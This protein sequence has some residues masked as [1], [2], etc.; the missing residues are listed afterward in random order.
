MG[1]ALGSGR[2]VIMLL[3]KAQGDDLQGNLSKVLHLMKLSTYCFWKMWNQFGYRL[4]GSWYACGGNFRTKCCF[5]T[6]LILCRCFVLASICEVSSCTSVKWD[7]VYI[8]CNCNFEGSC[9]KGHHEMWI[10]C[11]IMKSMF[12]FLILHKSY[13]QLSFVH[14]K[15]EI[16]SEF[17]KVGFAVSDSPSWKRTI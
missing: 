3:Q 1:T 17:M 2:I 10:P 9:F 6:L 12:P 13:V 4:L 7:T 16:G 11:I 8:G 14:M 5:E 15:C